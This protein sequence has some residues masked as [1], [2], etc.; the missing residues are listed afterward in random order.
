MVRKRKFQTVKLNVQSR[1]NCVSTRL[2]IAAAQSSMPTF[3]ASAFRRLC[4]SCSSICCFVVLA[5]SGQAV[6]YLKQ[7]GKATAK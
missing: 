7:K 5:T 2:A 6:A 1:R 4:L 3:G